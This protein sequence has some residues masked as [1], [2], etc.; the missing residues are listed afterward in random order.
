MLPI[1]QPAI[2][3]ANFTRAGI[4]SMAIVPVKEWWDIIVFKNK[5]SSAGENEVE[6]TEQLRIERVCHSSQ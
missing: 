6:T 1:V 5:N 3:P 2:S 4:A